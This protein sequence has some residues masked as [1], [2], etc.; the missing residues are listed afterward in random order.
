MAKVVDITE[1]LSFDTA[2]TIKIGDVEIKVNTDAATMLKI[3]GVLSDNDS[4]GPKEIIKMYNLMFEE[5]E[6]QKIER[7][8]LNFT[9]FTT[10]IY[11]AISLVTGEAEQGEQ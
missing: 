3:M 11:T 6:R 4:P 5:S 10:I 7:L 8:K 1:K 2:P 9:D